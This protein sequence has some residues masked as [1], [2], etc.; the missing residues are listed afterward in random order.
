MRVIDNKALLLRLRN[1]QQVTQVIPKSKALP[2]NKVVVNWGIDETHV[3]KNLGINAPAPIEG[4][5][6]WTGKHQPFAHQ[7]TTSSFLTLN[8]RA[9][10][11]NEQ[12]TCKTASAIWSAD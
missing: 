11:F 5:Y 8:K 2:D 7:K 4:R 1:E 3:L 12:G 10:C 6:K 9:F